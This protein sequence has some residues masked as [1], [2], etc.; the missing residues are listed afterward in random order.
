MCTIIDDINRTTNSNSSINPLQK[1]VLVIDDDISSCE[2]LYELFDKENYR[3]L[4]GINGQEGVRILTEHQ[5][6]N[7]SIDIII[8]DKFM[9]VMDGIEFLKQ[10]ILKNYSLT[11]IIMLSANLNQKETVEAFRNGVWDTITK[12]GD[13]EIVL[14]RVKIQLDKVA[15]LKKEAVKQQELKRLV[16]ADQVT[17][18]PNVK[19]FF[20][21]FKNINNEI[22]LLMINLD[23]FGDINNIYGRPIGDEML[24]NVATRLTNYLGVNNYMARLGGAEFVLIIDQPV[25]DEII[26]TANI[27]KNTINDTY[28][29]KDLNIHITASIGISFYPEHGKEITTLLKHANIAASLVSMKGNRILEF[30]EEMLVKIRQENEIKNDLRHALFKDPQQFKIYYQPVVDRDKKAVG[31]EALIRWHHPKNGLIPP[32]KFIP[33]AEKSE[34]LMVPLTELV[35]ETVC[36]KINEWHTESFYVS[37]NIS[38]IDLLSDNFITKLEALIGQYRLNRDLLKI[39]ITESHIMEDPEKAFCVIKD[40]KEKCKLELLID[41]FGTGHSALSYLKRFPKRTIVKID[42]SFIQSMAL[43]EEE[44]LTLYGIINLALTRNMPIVIEGVDNVPIPKSV[45]TEIEGINRD[46]SECIFDDIKYIEKWGR[47]SHDFQPYANTFTFK[48]S[49]DCFERLNL[50]HNI[51][52]Q[53][54]ENNVFE[55]LKRFSVETIFKKLKRFDINRF[56]GFYFDKPLT[57]EDFEKKYINS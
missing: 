15:Y 57:E 1:T 39:E 2:I 54:L 7:E 40:I 51:A 32:F 18:L 43:N 10:P 38:T 5:D 52:R 8:L 12:Q 35:M 11:P 45:F 50:N 46:Q 22:A 34:D 16:Y 21:K 27:L 20:N 14:E 56:Q 37:V 41:D 25:K 29:I 33:I 44:K 42:Q 47:L 9:P 19:A 30:N 55:I 53:K 24:K 17:N 36:K 28:Q 49:D 6:S 23:N 4:V 3:V 26:K 48:L 13:L 31:A